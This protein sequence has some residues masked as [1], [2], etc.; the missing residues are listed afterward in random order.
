M[1]QAIHKDEITYSAVPPYL[2]TYPSSAL[3]VLVAYKLTCH[4]S[5]GNLQ[6]GLRQF[7]HLPLSVKLRLQI[8]SQQYMTVKLP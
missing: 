5:G 2:T 3:L 8:V 1:A 6:V 7:H 4:K